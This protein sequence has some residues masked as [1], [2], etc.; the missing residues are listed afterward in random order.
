MIAIYATSTSNVL[1]MELSDGEETDDIDDSSNTKQEASPKLQRQRSKQM[2]INL[3][4]LAQACDHR[5][6]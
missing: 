6:F 4:S 3:P 1:D 2:R 5:G